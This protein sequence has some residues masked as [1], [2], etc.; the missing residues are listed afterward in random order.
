MDITRL[1]MLC[2]DAK[3]ITITSSQTAYIKYYKEC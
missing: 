1:Q 3:L 2:Y